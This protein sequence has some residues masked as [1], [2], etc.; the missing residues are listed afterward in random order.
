MKSRDELVNVVTDEPYNRI[1]G[2]YPPFHERVF[3]MYKAL[4]RKT[5]RHDGQGSIVDR[6]LKYENRLRDWNFDIIT[7]AW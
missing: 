2:Q 3:L 7:Y 1:A 6:S 4:P 5:P